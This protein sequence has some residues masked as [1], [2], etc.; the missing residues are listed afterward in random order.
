MHIARV[1]GGDAV[2]V[3]NRQSVHY[4]SLWMDTKA[5]ML[6]YPSIV[7]CSEDASIL[8]QLCELA[9]DWPQNRYD[10]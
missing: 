6:R 7:A 8:N 10:G 2:W 5:G 9:Q 4:K 1:R 3:H